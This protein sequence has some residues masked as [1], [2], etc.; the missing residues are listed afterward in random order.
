LQ[1]LLWTRMLDSLAPLG[2]VQEEAAVCRELMHGRQSQIP[3]LLS[4]S[5]L[6]RTPPRCGYPPALV[7]PIVMMRAPFLANVRLEANITTGP[8]EGP[9]VPMTIAL[10]CR[11]MRLFGHQPEDLMVLESSVKSLRLSRWTVTRHT[12]LAHR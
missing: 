12:T 2:M 10:T 9:M 4:H 3:D 8:M 11:A 7:Y 6:S 1:K 5:E